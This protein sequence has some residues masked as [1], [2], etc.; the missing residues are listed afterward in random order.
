MFKRIITGM[1]FAMIIALTPV[2]SQTWVEADDSGAMKLEYTVITKAQFDR[3]LR[4]FEAS[5]KYASFNFEDV[6]LKKPSSDEIK[7]VSGRKP[8]FNGYYY[9]L[10]KITIDQSKLTEDERADVAMYISIIEGEFL[11]Y[12]HKDTGELTINFPDLYAAGILMFSNP[13]SFAE[14]NSDDYKPKLEQFLGL[15]EGK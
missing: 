4:Q 10:K 7:I 2:F 6:L 1:L 11:I 8:I 13:G 9:L 15:V 3:L 14:I 12:G 5:K